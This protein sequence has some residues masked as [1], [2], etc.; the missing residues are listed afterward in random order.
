MSLQDFDTH[1]N[2]LKIFIAG[3]KFCNGY[4]ILG[5]ITKP[6]ICWYY[7][8]IVY[9]GIKYI[10][11]LPSNPVGHWPR[12]DDDYGGVEYLFESCNVRR[13]IEQYCFTIKSSGNLHLKE[14]VTGSFYDDVTFER[15]F[16]Y[17]LND[18]THSSAQ[19]S[20]A[21]GKEFPF[22]LLVDAIFYYI[23]LCNLVRVCSTL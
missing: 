6:T 19:K 7:N 18:H 8:D 13:R 21:S 5:V 4:G 9:D 11:T 1:L 20:T 2:K 10:F 23:L 14:I 17:C 16:D 12:S 22:I 15:T 3:P